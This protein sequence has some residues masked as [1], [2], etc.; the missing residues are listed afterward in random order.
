MP[1]VL[2]WM[3][4]L[5]IYVEKKIWTNSEI[6]LTL[7]RWK[8]LDNSRVGVLAVTLVWRADKRISSFDVNERDSCVSTTTGKCKILLKLGF[9]CSFLNPEFFFNYQSETTNKFYF[10]SLRY[11]HT[12]T[13]TH[14]WMQ[15]C[16][17][18][19]ILAYIRT[20]VHTYIHT[21]CT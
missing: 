7:N 3:S 13:H 10:T 20:Y 11:T 9:T 6:L 16:I 21:Y 12:Y 4:S 19:H 17:R 14:T 2:T 18:T 15:L 1:A 5:F 8:E